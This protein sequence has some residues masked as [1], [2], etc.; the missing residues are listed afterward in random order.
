MAKIFRTNQTLSNAGFNQVSGQT[1]SLLGNT[2]IGR[3]T[4]SSNQ[5]AN[6]N[7]LSVVDKSYVDLVVSGLKIHEPVLA[8]TVGNISLS[9]LTGSTYVDTILINSGDRVLVKNQI[10]GRLNGIYVLSGSSEF[11]RA[12]DFDESSEALLGTY[13]FAENGLVNGG[14]RWV[15]ITPNPI[16]INVTPLQFIKFSE[17]TNIVG[18]TGI[19]VNLSSGDYVVSVDGQT[20]VGN[21]LYWSGNTF[22]VDVNS[23]TLGAALATLSGMSAGGT[24]NLQS[25]S[26]I[27]LGGIAAGTVLTGKTAFQL[28][29]ELLVPELCG[30][31][32]APSVGIGL[33]ISGLVEI[34]CNFSQTV[35][36]TFNRGCINPQ[37]CSTSD[38][39]S[40]CANA[41]CFTGTGMPS[42]Y[43][44]C[45]LSPATYVN[46]S[47][48]VVVGTQSWGVCT[49][50]NA[51]N[52]ALGSK[53]T[54]YCAA[55]ASG[56]TSAASS[57]ITG[58]YPLFGT[59]SNITTLTKQSLVAM[60]TGNN[61]C[62]NLVTESNPNK[63]KFEIPCAWLGVPTNRPLVG[64]CQWNTVSSSWEY[65]GGSAG[66][67]LSLWTA[68]SSSETIQ[69]NSIG[70][71][72]YTYNG[73][74]RSSVC[75]RLVF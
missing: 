4:Y 53:G 44:T 17:P 69:G 26:V 50:Y 30:T 28:F 72:Q 31:I 61:V 34:G 68:S 73:V 21:S 70:Y 40:G 18:G 67:S 42:G 2:T 58:V 24:Y 56:N 54:Q 48:S 45:S 37:Y 64:V 71:C 11:I 8:A 74:D 15:L 36:G 52:P 7:D 39:R 32:T 46:P 3:M 6:Y 57:S 12:T 19:T 10:D 51:G 14:S 43:Q 35:T 25:P 33:T 75:I 29:E 5:H 49:R 22:N 65:P 20:L 55:L 16:I 59:T 27:P 47:Y 1:L 41:Y 9:G 23:G 63:Q 38:K 60:T 66:S 13:V 62:M